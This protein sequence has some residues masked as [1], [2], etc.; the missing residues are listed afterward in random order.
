MTARIGPIGPEHHTALLRLNTRFVHWLSPLDAPGL[1]ALLSRCDYARQ[2]GGRAFLLG[3]PGSTDHRHKNVDWLSAR[4]RSYAYI[5]RVVV[6]PAAAGQG[7]MRALYADFARWA[8]GRG[9]GRL[10]CEVNTRPDN[11]ASHRAHLAL[12]FTA[13]GEAE[14]GELAVRYYVRGLAPKQQ[15]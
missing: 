15:R 12:G 5:D 10:A 7:H 14:H 6:D 13:L 3:Y 4:L 2:I 1:H 9:L 11:P 8:E